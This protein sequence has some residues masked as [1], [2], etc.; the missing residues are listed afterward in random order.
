MSGYRKYHR[1]SLN[2]SE[3]LTVRDTA[4]EMADYEKQQPRER[5]FST[6][7]DQQVLKTGNLAFIAEQGENGGAATYQE[8]SGAP[9][10]ARSPLGLS[11]SYVCNSIDLHGP[12]D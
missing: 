8:A 3:S 11:V 7:G 6:E 9:V 10:E 12:K 5:T 4:I 2:S 1:L